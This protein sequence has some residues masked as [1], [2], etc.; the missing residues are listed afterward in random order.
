VAD[1]PGSKIDRSS[2]VPFYFQLKKMLAEE[3]STGRWPPGQRLPSEP[4]ICAHFEVSRTTVRQ[5]L[6]ELEAEGMI[7]RERGR[8][9][10]IAQP[11]STSWLLQSSHGFFDEATAAGRSVTSILLRREKAPLPPWASDALK[12]PVGSDGVV[13]GRL[14]WV[15]D[16]LVM[17]VINYLPAY[18]AGTVMEADLE[19]G[20][21]YRVLEERQGL[22]V[23]GGRR[24][25]EAVSARD[26]LARL[27]KV[28]PDTPLLLVESVSW[29][30][31]G[32]P[33]ECYQAWHR[34]DRTKIEVQVVHHEIAAKAGFDANAMRIGGP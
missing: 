15:D 27:L 24:V 23:S 12:L 20:S 30:V 33:F 19:T 21:L 17:Y 34:A 11:R 18:L 7:R 28:E 32:H 25:V 29:A 26:D 5:A 13:L 6:A 16:Q 2:P 9:T 8:G 3:I 4:S 1:L 14:R 10:F 22:S 31:D